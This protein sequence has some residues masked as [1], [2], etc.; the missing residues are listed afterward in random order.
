MSESRRSSRAHQA[1]HRAPRLA[2]WPSQVPPTTLLCR[3]LSL[4][5]T[6]SCV[7]TPAALHLPFHHPQP[8][9]FF[10][11]TDP[12]FQEVVNGWEAAGAVRRWD[13]PVGRL[14]AASGSFSP[15]PAAPPRYVATGGMRALAQHLEA[16][17]GGGGKGGQQQGQGQG[18]K[19]GLVEFRRPCWVGKMQVSPLGAAGGGERRSERHGGVRAGRLAGCCGLGGR[20]RHSACCR[21]CVAGTVVLR[22][23]H[24]VPFARPLPYR[25]R[26]C[27]H[28]TPQAEADRGWALSGEGR[29]QGVYDAVVIAHNG[30]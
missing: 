18:A 4:V 10:T 23:P 7:P 15:L 13:G 6:L 17:L 2:P 27:C 24:A 26:P 29:S 14:D 16:Q 28:L 12:D 25:H 5:C 9:Q 21:I 19:A 8:R 11:V 3:R 1:L 30:K 22:A 20:V